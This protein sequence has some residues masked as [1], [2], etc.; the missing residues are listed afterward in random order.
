MPQLLKA[1]DHALQADD[2]ELLTVPATSSVEC[3]GIQV[4]LQ[5]RNMVWKLNYVATPL[6]ILLVMC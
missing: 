3:H 4:A 1:E 6:H 5:G 2:D